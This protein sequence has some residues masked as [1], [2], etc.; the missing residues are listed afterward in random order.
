[1]T[2]EIYKQD[3]TR[4]E[5]LEDIKRYIREVGFWNLQKQSEL[6]AKYGVTQQMI[7][8]DIE[9]I[10]KSFDPAELDEVFTEC[11][12]ADKKAMKEVRKIMFQGSDEDKLKAID[13]MLKVQKGITELLEAYSKKQKVADKLQVAAV[14]YNFKIEKPDEVVYEIKTKEDKETNDKRSKHKLEAKQ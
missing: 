13:T 5:R 8:K 2:D 11:F 4:K 7:C 10:V 14:S 6:A 3:Y 9:K 1:M 12:N